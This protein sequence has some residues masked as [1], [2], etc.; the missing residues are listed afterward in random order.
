MST[1]E[2]AD[3]LLSPRLPIVLNDRRCP[4]KAC[5][6]QEGAA[7]CQEAEVA[8]HCFQKALIGEQGK[9]CLRSGRMS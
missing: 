2:L 3:F 8:N 9:A 4:G 6:V 7:G 1:S 5:A